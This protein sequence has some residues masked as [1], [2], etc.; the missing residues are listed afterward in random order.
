MERVKIADHIADLF[1]ERLHRVGC[2]VVYDP[3]GRYWEIALGLDGDECRVIDAAGS[4]IFARE[5]A[6]RAW[7]AI[8]DGEKRLLVHVP[9]P[10]PLEEQDKQADPFHPLALGGAVFP[11]GEGDS[12]LALC[13]VAKPDRQAR[14]RDLFEAEEPSFTTV[15]ALDGG[16][17]WPKL[18]TILSAVS[19]R[20]ILVS[21]LSPREE[22]RRQL[23]ADTG[24]LAEY[25]RFAANVLGLEVHS[26][27]ATWT[28]VR[29]ELAR[30]VLFSEFALDLPGELP[31]SLV[32]V[33]RAGDDDRSLVYAV[34]DQLRNHRSHEEDYIELA[35]QVSRELDLPART[36]AATDFGE[37]DTFLFEERGFLHRCAEAA[38]AG[39]LDSA[40]AIAEQR[41]GSIWVRAEERATEW[42]VAGHALGLLRAIADLERELSS[43]GEGVAPLVTF[44][45][46]RARRADALHRALEGTLHDAL[47]V[48]AGLEG[49]IEA[50]RTRYRTL[51]DA[52]QKHFLDAIRTEGWPVA[53]FTRH[54]QVFKKHVAPV[55]ERRKKVALFM[56]DALR[57]ELAAEF[58]QRLPEGDNISLAPVLAQ[59]PTITSVGMAALLPGADA[60]LR[61]SAT[62][63][64]LVPV[65]DG[66][67]VSTPTERFE[68]VRRLYGDRCAMVD[69]DA[70]LR[71]RPPKIANTVD[72]LLV[73]NTE[74]D[75]AGENLQIG[76]ALGVI[77]GTLGKLF[78]ALR[79][80]G[81]RGFDQAVL[82]ADHGFVLLS[83]QL[84]GDKVE[85]PRGT[86]ALSKVR[87]VAG[88]GSEAPG[89]A[90]FR[91][92]D[93]GI[94]GDIEQLAVPAS[95]GAFRTGAAFMHSGISLQECV[96]P[97]VEVGLSA[98]G[99]G[100]RPTAQIE[101]R[102]RGGATNRITTRRPMIEVVLFQESVFGTEE[103]RFSL[104][105]R[106]GRN[107]AGEVAPSP[108][109]DSTTGLVSIE[110]GK[111]I[112]VP[113]R[114]REDFEGEFT[115]VAAD[116]ATKVIFDE[117][118]LRTDYV[119]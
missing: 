33:P 90:S 82:A 10:K 41:R 114:M 40:F 66:A 84:P 107:I 103:V 79:K 44:Y 115:V 89:V 47:G 49:L 106:S 99:K 52:L 51:A 88:T 27:V 80:L 67:R 118:K 85:R 93:V 58:A 35:G 13:L 75:A 25:R 65:I 104:E 97:V 19:Q 109:V 81:D 111:A 53:G 68:H 98:S 69:L 11:E 56:V 62:S 42:V 92:E 38:E 74:I 117:L 14:I 71:S 72:L 45:A 91:R 64:D 15:D 6:M 102:Y 83:E 30:F 95:L 50:A 110:T 43:V 23:I 55:L 1:Q 57:Y 21:L 36:S 60:G 12:Y 17:T 116:P 86:W 46:E 100:A 39:N 101:L 7:V 119:E 78:R 26:Q 63:D 16:S 28:E 59:V 34:C 31:A 4:A 94:D 112:K 9:A 24:W 48:P 96:V 113:L 20:E 29:D 37:R 105:A 5:T 32:D 2:L 108:N 76:A 3:T 61:L 22:Q 8:A 70:L 18:R 77:R 54:T 73:K 87:C